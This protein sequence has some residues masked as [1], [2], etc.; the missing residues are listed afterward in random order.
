MIDIYH[1]LKGGVG[2]YYIGLICMCLCLVQ[3]N[4][5]MY[6]YVTKGAIE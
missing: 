3:P 4:I 6:I 2:L 5:T 1:P